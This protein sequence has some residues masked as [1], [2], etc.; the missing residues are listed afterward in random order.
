M[1]TT[2]HTQLHSP[3]AAQISKGSLS[4]AWYGLVSAM[5]FVYIG[6]ALAQAY[7]TVDAIIGLVLTIAVFGAVNRVLSAYA[8]RHGL[9]VSQFSRSLLGRT[10]ALLATLIFAATAVYYAV[11]EG[12][13][14]AFAFQAQFGGPMPLW[15][16]AVVLYTTPLVAGGI[17]RWLDKINGWLLPLYWGGLPRRGL[18]RR[19]ARF[20]QQLADAQHRSAALR[21]GRSRL[22]GHLRRLHGRVSH[23]DVHHGLRCPRQAGGHRVPPALHLRLALLHARLRRQRADRHLPDLHHPGAGRHRNRRGRR[24]GP[25]DGAAGAAG[26][27]RLADPDQ[28]RQLRPRN[29]E[30]QGVPGADPALSRSGRRLGR[31]RRRAHLPADAAAGGGLPAAG[32]HV[33]GRHG[34]RLGRHRPGPHR[35][36]PAQRGRRRAGRPAGPGLRGR[37]PGRNCCLA[38]FGGHRHCVRAVR[39]A[40]GRHRGHA[41]HS[42]RRLRRGPDGHRRTALLARH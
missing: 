36:G 34:H 17:R 16:A 23:D 21:R 8:L 30:P 20:H 19:R 7:G 22:A 33:A 25:A 1:T 27:L 10:G 42:R 26:G 37:Q 2:D 3:D 38:G 6:A 24:T 14:L 28:H 9:T 29:L 4:M 5:F 39:R 32:P 11:F 41:G 13:I 12:S 31:C 18:G 15:Y 40:V 35:D